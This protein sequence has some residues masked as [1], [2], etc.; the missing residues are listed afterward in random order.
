MKFH[1]GI[2][3]YL[4]CYAHQCYWIRFK[5]IAVKW[6]NE[7]CLSNPT[8][9]NYTLIS[10]SSLLLN[11]VDVSRIFLNQFCEQSASVWNVRLLGELMP[12]TV[13]QEHIPTTR[14][15]DNLDQW[16]MYAR[17][18]NVRSGLLVAKECK[19]CIYLN[20]FPKLCQC[21]CEGYHVLWVRYTQHSS[22]VHSMYLQIK[23]RS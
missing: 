22:R 10:S 6:S 8:F 3:I 16:T 9:T 12:S 15:E 19:F 5:C 2:D 7:H 11:T 4:Q 1:W 23:L 14:M 21:Y 13:S 17:A 18:F 20:L